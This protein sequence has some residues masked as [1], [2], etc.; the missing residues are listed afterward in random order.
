[1]VETLLHHVYDA[2]VLSTDLQPSQTVTMLNGQDITITVSNNT[3]T[4]TSA[5]GTTAEV[6]VADQAGTNG[7][8]HII[9]GVLVPTL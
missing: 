7:V 5:G 4:I 2:L 9:D 3:V 8:V 1:V 6:T